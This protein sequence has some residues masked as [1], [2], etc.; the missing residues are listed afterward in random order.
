[1][2]EDFAKDKNAFTLINNILSINKYIGASNGAAN[3]KKS[4]FKLMSIISNGTKAS[5]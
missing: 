3:C 4:Y 5:S 1:M 2:L